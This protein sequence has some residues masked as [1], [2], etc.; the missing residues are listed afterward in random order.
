LDFFL[1]NPKGNSSA[2]YLN[3]IAQISL[4]YHSNKTK[5][6][7]IRI[8]LGVP[9][10]LR[11]KRQVGSSGTLTALLHNPNTQ[12]RSNNTY[13]TSRALLLMHFYENF[14]LRP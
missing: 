11:L 5:F 7:D 13:H 1:S 4:G 9:C 12:R 3:A 10:L 6:A 8:L 2:V 14:S